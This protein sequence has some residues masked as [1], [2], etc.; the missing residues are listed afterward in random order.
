MLLGM[1]KQLVYAFPGFH[2]KETISSNNIL[3]INLGNVNWVNDIFDI[4]MLIYLLIET[5][6]MNESNLI[7]LYIIF[8]LV[9]IIIEYLFCL[10]H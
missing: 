4:C 10:N 1:S 9:I 2:N 3:I 7:S 5:I 8:G 6:N